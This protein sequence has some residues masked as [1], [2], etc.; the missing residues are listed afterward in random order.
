MN[1]VVGAGSGMGEAVARALGQRGDLLLA[2]RS[3]E[4]VEMVAE[5]IGS[6]A[7][8]VACD[9]TSPADLEALAALV[10][11]L[12]GLVITAGLSPSMG[13][14]RRILEVN[15]LG[16][17]A[18]LAALDGAVQ[19]RT[20]AVCFASI[21]GHGADH[22]PEVVE[23]LYD[24]MAVDFFERLTNV[25]IDLAD[26]GR[27]YSLSKQGVIRLA[28]RLAGV[29]GPRG[30]RIVSLSPGVIDTPMGQ[31]EFENQP[32]MRDM[33]ARSSLGRAGRPEEV[34]AVAAFLCSPAASYVTGC[35][36]LVDGG[37]RAALSS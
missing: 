9:V 22:P 23:V 26:P 37:F 28:R 21:A 1:V 15:L 14:G 18:L 36:V 25:G 19:E 3:G 27:A 12:D 29:W 17:A 5:S 20:A 31:L 24:P 16:M 10:D 13:S 32:V 33:V 2:D 11:R 35:D 34:A 4:A 6:H 30:A 8:A 7:R